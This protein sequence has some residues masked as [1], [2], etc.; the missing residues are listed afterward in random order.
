[1]FQILFYDI[2]LDEKLHGTLEGFVCAYAYSEDL[3]LKNMSFLECIPHE[4]LHD[5]LQ[6]PYTLFIVSVKLN[7]IINP[8]ERHAIYIILCV[9]VV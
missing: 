2:C 3:N 8:P 4:V 5:D 1:M 7:S 9:G 6:R